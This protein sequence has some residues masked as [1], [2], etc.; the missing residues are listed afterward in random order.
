MLSR[1]A[2]RSCSPPCALPRCERR[3][4]RACVCVE[5]VDGCAALRR[6]CL[7]CTS[8]VC[9]P[10]ARFFSFF[11]VFFIFYFVHWLF[12]PCDT[13]AHHTPS[14][15]TQAMP[16]ESPSPMHAGVTPVTLT[17]RSPRAPVSAKFAKAARSPASAAHPSPAS[18]GASPMFPPA[19]RPPRM[20][21]PY[22]KALLRRGRDCCARPSPSDLR[23]C[24]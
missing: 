7:C 18:K 24:Y 23:L 3:R 12:N 14:H 21:C 5:C 2:R 8:A 6:S 16:I 4:A 1:R 17:R 15:H 11:C 19:P 10:A 13:H 9:L 22:F 20:C